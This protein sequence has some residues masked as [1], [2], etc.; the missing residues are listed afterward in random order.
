MQTCVDTLAATG[1]EDVKHRSGTGASA[2]WL[3]YP[4]NY[5]GQTT[6]KGMTCK[7]HMCPESALMQHSETSDHVILVQNNW[8]DKPCVHLMKKMN[9]A[10]DGDHFFVLTKTKSF[11]EFLTIQQERDTEE[12]RAAADVDRWLCFAPLCTSVL[13]VRCVYP[14][15]IGVMHAM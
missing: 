13:S 4:S 12:K 5:K 7:A 11:Q 1:V 8:Q 14:V 3:L 2:L 15:L 9:E 10:R 6:P